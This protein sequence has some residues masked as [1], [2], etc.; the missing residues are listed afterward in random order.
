VANVVPSSVA[1]RGTSARALARATI[2]GDF[3]DDIDF[4]SDMD[5]QALV[6]EGYALSEINKYSLK[7]L[8]EAP[9]HRNRRKRRMP[10]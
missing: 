7:Q 8:R 2:Y 1:S 5:R 10:T 3:V 4:T 6:K 9:C